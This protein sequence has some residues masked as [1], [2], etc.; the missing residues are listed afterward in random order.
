MII[1]FKNHVVCWCLISDTKV[2]KQMI[3]NY[4]T[5]DSKLNVQ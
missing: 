2:T 3:S 4:L 1:L 5:I